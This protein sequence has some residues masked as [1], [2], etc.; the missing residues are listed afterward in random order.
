MAASEYRVSGLGLIIL[1]LIGLCSVEI[2]VL[3]G[4]PILTIFLLRGVADTSGNLYPEVNC[5]LFCDYAM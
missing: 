1:C 4:F 3:S 5:P 2:C